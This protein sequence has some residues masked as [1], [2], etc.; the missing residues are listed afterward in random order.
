M[1]YSMKNFEKL[2]SKVYCLLGDAEM[3]E[4][5]NWEAMNFASFYKLDNLIAIVDVNRLG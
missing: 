1:A 4:G 3:A 5:S 2:T